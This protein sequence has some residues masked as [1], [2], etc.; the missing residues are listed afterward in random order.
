MQ[1]REFITILGGAAAWPI[2]ARA[3]QA[4]PI[5]G[6]LGSG[7][8]EPARVKVFWGALN[9]AGYVE[10][11][12]CTIEFRWA[13]GQYDQLSSLAADLINRRVSL[14]VASGPPAARVAKA[15]TSTIPI[16]FTIG[17]DPIRDGLVDSLSRPGGNVTGVTLFTVNLAAKRLGLLRDLVPHARTIGIL[18]NPNASIAEPQ[19]KDVQAAVDALGLKLHVFEATTEGELDNAFATI[20]KS[21]TDAL[22]VGNDPFFNSQRSKIAALAAHHAVPTIYE[23]REYAEAGGLM[24]YG[25]IASDVYRQAGIYAGR[26]L[27]GAQPANLP[28]LQPTRFELVIN[29]KT[30]KVL[31]LQVP[32]DVLTL[33]DVVIE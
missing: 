8:P 15:A 5:I 14:I 13:E 2:M 21:R 24:S 6:F 11:R 31:G 27:K 28:V 25:T 1:R 4:I 16:V 20:E 9:E 33:A 10:G 3:Q 23:W 17:S 30:A 12:N 18:V 29:L 32:P 19:K 22:V 26:I 7:S